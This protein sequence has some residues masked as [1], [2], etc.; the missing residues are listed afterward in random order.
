MTQ[1]DHLTEEQF[2]RYRS[3]QLPPAELL[4]VD[5]H[6]AHCE[7]CRDRLYD[8][9][10][11]A[12]HL[13]QLK[14][15]LS[16][17]LAYDQ[18]AACA[19]GSVSPEA[20]V[21]LKDCAMCRAEVDDLTE[22]RGELAGPPRAPIPMP[23]RAVR[24]RLPAAAAI[25]LAAGISA[26]IMAHGPRSSSP[27]AAVAHHESPLSAEQQQLVANA[28]SSRRLERAPVLDR[29]ITRRS[30]LLGSADSG[31][32]FDLIGP[33]GTTEVTDRPTFHW[34]SAPGATR[35][36]VALFDENFQKLAESPALTA[37][38]WQPE[39]PLER[40]RIYN[41]QVNAT[42]GGKTVHAPTP[43]APEA[44]FQV[45]SADASRQIDAAR[46]EH[47]ANHLLIAALLA[48]FG[49]LDEALGEL[50]QVTDPVAAD[51]RQSL[52]AMRK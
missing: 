51:L 9:Q 1:P 20:R 46:H 47:P 43:P 40:G 39:Q 12:T 18:I 24:W 29:L 49:A 2:S 42:V 26:W 11:A 21:H 14:I 37:T 32:N 35:Y 19:D 23:V 52:T 33:M 7:A 13:R 41:W 50:D 25:L 8:Q 31:A 17:H 10:R 27:T 48:Q 5:E 22:F 15:E 3:R 6:A 34:T 38:Q 36:V 30:I 28:L 4:H 45:V 16:E 44:R